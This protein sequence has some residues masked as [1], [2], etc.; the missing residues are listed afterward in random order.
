MVTYSLTNVMSTDF[1]DWERRHPD[2]A[3]KEFAIQSP[4]IVVNTGLI[5]DDFTI[6]ALFPVARIARPSRVFKNTTRKA[7]TAATAMDAVCDPSLHRG[8]FQNILH[9]GKHRICTVHV[10]QG[11]ASHHCYVNRIQS[12]IHN[13]SRKQ[14]VYSHFCLQKSGYK[15]RTDSGKHCWYRYGVFHDEGCSGRYPSEGKN[16]YNCCAGTVAVVVAFLVVFL[17]TRLGLAIRATGN[18]AD[19]VKS[20]LNLKATV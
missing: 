1:W 17:K 4:I 20:L 19:M 2:S 14:T 6:S 16:R 7:T 8:I 9:H 5:D 18:N 15:T 3:V 12:C 11:R 13:N 10:D